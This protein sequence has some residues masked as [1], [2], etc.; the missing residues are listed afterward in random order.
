MNIE[1]LKAFDFE[2]KE[3]CDVLSIVLS[4]VYGREKGKCELY[5]GYVTFYK[6]YLKGECELMFPT[7]EGDEDGREIY[8]GHI[9]EYIMPDWDSDDFT[10]AEKIRKIG[11]CEY[12]EGKFIHSER[13]FGY[14]GE[15]EIDLQYCRI[16]GLKY[17]EKD[18]ELLK[19]NNTR[20]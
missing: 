14:E 9:L 19:L 4:D 5:N 10:G 15:K 11:I 17:R 13:E 7:S 2:R 6:N 18:L 3:V 1:N 12:K 20:V 16:I 8:S